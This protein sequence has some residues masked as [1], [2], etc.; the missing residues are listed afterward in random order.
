MGSGYSYGSPGRYHLVERILVQGNE[1]VGWGA[2]SAGCDAFFGYPITPQN[3]IPEWFSREFPK[4]GKIFVQS[5]SE[6]ASI[7][8]VYGGAA[9][10]FRV[11][12][13]TSSPG[14]ALMQ[15]GMSHLAAAE[16]PCIIVLVQRGGPGQ[17]S[18]RHAQMDYLCTTR[19]GAGGYKNIIVA[20]ASVQETHDLVQL[21]FYLADK[22]RNPVIVL[23]DGILGL[24]RESLE[25][26][27][28]DFGPLPEKDWAVRGRERHKDKN[29]RF[30]HSGV[31]TAAVLTRGYPNYVSWLEHMADKYEQM[32]SEL[33]YESYQAEDAELFLVAYGYPARVC[34]EAVNMARTEGL[35]VGL[36]RPITLWPFPYQLIKGKAESGG[37]FLVVE[38]SLGLMV[39]DVR[40]AV[41]GQ[42]E[43]HFLGMQSR[44]LPTDGGMILPSR[45]LEEIRRLS[46]DEER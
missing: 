37:K 14:W 16:L 7:M 23:S 42:A 10:G 39:E 20:P 38:D 13:S 41:Q 26:K 33:K 28:M 6:I 17:G 1:A 35:K 31:G 30:V 4:R 3:E 44:H 21:A 22:Y 24:I 43:V 32:E 40:M 27:T 12:T 46:T 19:G 36:F 34:K 25:I 8:M 15:E 9:A 5:Q 2:L 29:F 45:V 18:I 11:M